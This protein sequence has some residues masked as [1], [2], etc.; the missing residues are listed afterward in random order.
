MLV[1]LG[2]NM[3][4]PGDPVTLSL[5]ETHVFVFKRRNEAQSAIYANS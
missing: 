3:F 2:L 1:S 5:D 4:S